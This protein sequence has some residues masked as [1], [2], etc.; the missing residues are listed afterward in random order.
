M[1]KTFTCLMLLLPMVRTSE[2]QLALKKGVHCQNLGIKNK[3]VENKNSKIFKVWEASAQVL[4]VQTVNLTECGELVQDLVSDAK[5]YDSRLVI[6]II[7]EIKKY[8]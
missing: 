4:V 3:K 1:G 6:I 8:A 2:V 7:M 5:D